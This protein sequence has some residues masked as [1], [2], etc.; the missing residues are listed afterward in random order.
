MSRYLQ[1]DFLRAGFR[2]SSGNSLAGGKVYCY[3]AGTSNLKALSN[4]PDGSTF[5]VNP[6]I[7]DARGSAEAWGNGKYK[8]V[9][10]DSG[11][12]TQYTWDNL[13]YS[14]PEDSNFYCGTSTGSSNA[15]VLTPSPSITSL[16][17]GAVYTFIANHAS[18]GAA[19]VNISGLGAKSLVKA[20]GITAITTGDITSQM[21]TDIRWINSSNH[22]RLV[23]AAGVTPI[24]NGGT[25]SST[26][27]GARTNLGLGTMAVQNANSVTIT[28]G[29]ITGTTT[30]GINSTNSSTNL[31]IAIGGV[32][33]GEVPVGTTDGSSLLTPA[34]NN[35]YT[36]G[37]SSTA[38]KN[39][40]SEAFTIKTK[41]QFQDS[42]TYDTAKLS[43][44]PSVA[45][46]KDVA[47][48]L[49]VLIKEL[50]RIGLVD[51]Y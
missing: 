24:S 11:D 36:L 50:S 1:V 18:S 16:E 45:T 31:T 29:A 30:T 3:E 12:V 17:D 25:G 40:H 21:L 8:F 13:D 32:V 19:T 23:S 37:I 33:K 5:H 22:F 27:S 9:I 28:G 51:F 15:Y 26:A 6:L 42:F 20:D 7:L 43:V 35:H 39:M 49:L 14:K 46:A 34:L 2:D 41:K 38:F 47:D 4:T 48:L 44:N 10:K